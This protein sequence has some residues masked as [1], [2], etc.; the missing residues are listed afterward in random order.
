MTTFTIEFPCR[1][2]IFELYRW[3]HGLYRVIEMN[4]LDAS[5]W[6]L[7]TYSLYSDGIFRSN[8]LFVLC[9]IEKLQRVTFQWSHGV[10]CG[11]ERLG[12]QSGQW[13][14]RREHLLLDPSYCS[15][16]FFLF[17]FYFIIPKITNKSSLCVDYKTG[18]LLC[19]DPFIDTFFL[20]KFS[21]IQNKNLLCYWNDI[22]S[23]FIIC[24][25]LLPFKLL[26][27][28]FWGL[29][30]HKIDW[31]KYY[32]KLEWI[33]RIIYLTLEHS[34]TSVFKYWVERDISH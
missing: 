9:L 12:K 4:V 28:L 3:Y 10:R 18:R 16:L 1:C 30:C 33:P 23:L 34:I 26:L 24:I 17:E 8:C 20:I 5:K 31:T 6:F 27:L 21:L 22:R 19:D 25:L 13:S 7:Q 29:F 14:V 11:R 32:Y 15:S 2:A